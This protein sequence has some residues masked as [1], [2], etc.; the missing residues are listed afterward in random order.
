[1]T[2]SGPCPA[3]I[4]IV[5]EAW[6]KHEEAAPNHEPFIGPSGHLLNQMLADAGI[7]RQSCF[8]ANVV[9][10]RP[11]GDKIDSYF[12]NKTQAKKLGRSPVLGR[13]PHDVVIRGL[14]DLSAN[15]SRCNPKLIIAL[16]NTPLWALT[17][18]LGIMKWRGSQLYE[19]DRAIVPTVH[20]AALLRGMQSLR[21]IVVH[22]FGRAN[23]VLQGRHKRP[24]WR[25]E[26]RPS[27]RQVLERLEY[28]LNLRRT[29]GELSC[30]IETR[31]GQIA[32]VGLAWDIHE[33]IC[34]P[35]MSLTQR[36]GYWSANEEASVVQALRQ[37]LTYRSREQDEAA[38]SLVFQ[39]GAY[40]LQYFAAQWGYLP[41]CT[42]DTMLMQHTL[43]PGLKK[44]L[45]FLASMYC[46]Y[47]KYWK[48]DG[49]EFDPHVAP[50]TQLWEYNCEDCIR[51]LEI[52]RVLRELIRS[53]D[54]ETQYRF[55]MQVF[56]IAVQMMLRGV[57][58]DG[59]AQARLGK[60]LDNFAA[61]RKEW[62]TRVLARE[63]NYNS[64]PQM[65]NLFY[66]EMGLKP[67]LKRRKD[68]TYGQT[69]DDEALN[70]IKRREPLLKPLIDTI[71]EL[72]SI[73]VFKSNYAEMPVSPDGRMRSS[74]N[75]AGTETY[76]FSMSEDAFGYGGNLQT[77]PKGTEDK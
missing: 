50:E 70:K 21:P 51:T 13:F 5:G 38:P 11:P 39:N 10:A 66:N 33:A 26:V 6:G 68:G 34:I 7:S 75:L 74:I 52:Y 22:D 62:L 77:I 25:F 55:Q 42:D 4:M 45:D 53:M 1:M 20:P 71:Q 40:D 76:R 23:G 24:Q 43:F 54:R 19:N 49:K 2:T 57:R 8:V 9:N 72:R 32:C 14:S 15:I 61:S 29:G 48:D 60:Q 16:G 12:Y 3:E 58:I 67:V 63:F 30:D 41:T 35:F 65:V 18:N 59:A 64:H 37:V 17:G 73:G 46:D 31:G 36:E 27:H 56:K 69:C 47:Y 28:L 44:A